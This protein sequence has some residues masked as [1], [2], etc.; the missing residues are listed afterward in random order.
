MQERGF[1]WR[2]KRHCLNGEEEGIMRGGRK[3]GKR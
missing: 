3:E 1:D 2:Q